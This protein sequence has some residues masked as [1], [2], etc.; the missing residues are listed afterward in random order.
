M[1]R[2]TNNISNIIQC[3][4]CQYTMIDATVLV[5][6]GQTYCFECIFECL[7]IY[8]NKDPIT[9]T[10]YDETDLIPNYTVRSMIENLDDSKNKPSLEENKE[11]IIEAKIV[12]SSNIR[13]CKFG[14]KCKRK[15]CW[16]AHPEGQASLLT[17]H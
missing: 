15:G 6:S 3:P 16:F 13:D 17:I 2:N 12:D 7:K 11:I 4:I 9:N 1:F 5:P 10:T 8:P 14:K